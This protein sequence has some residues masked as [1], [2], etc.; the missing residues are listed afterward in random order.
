MLLSAR[1]RAAACTRTGE[2]ER[3]TLFWYALGL[4]GLQ[5]ASAAPYVG[6]VW[7]TLPALTGSVLL[8]L[9]Y[10]IP[11]FNHR[12]DGYCHPAL[13]RD[14]EADCAARSSVAARP[15]SGSCA[16]CRRLC[17]WACVLGKSCIRLAPE[18][19]L[20]VYAPIHTRVLLV[21][22]LHTSMNFVRKCK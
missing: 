14:C 12:I 4:G 1:P 8:P 16:S 5:H 9:L 2:R 3:S 22:T 17:S 11:D 10:K 18:V 19:L 21:P 6:H 15:A 13:R 20:Q 7:I